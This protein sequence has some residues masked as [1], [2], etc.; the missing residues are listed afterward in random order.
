MAENIP[1]RVQFKRMTAEEWAR[2]DVILLEGEIG[3]ETDTG[4]AK[5]GNGK[6]Q[7]KDLKY[8][9]GPQGKTGET[10]PQGPPGKQGQT[11]EIGP[12][13]PPGPRGETGP[14]GPKGADGK[15]TFEQLTP[16][17]R[18]QL[19]GDKGPKGDVGPKGNDGAPGKS[20]TIRSITEETGGSYL[21]SWFGSTAKSTKVT[22][23]DGQSI[24]L[25]H[26]KDGETG[27]KGERGLPGKDGAP[28]MDGPR[29]PRGATG[30]AGPPGKD[31]ELPRDVLT[32][33]R[34]V[35]SLAG[36]VKLADAQLLFNNIGKLKDTKTGQFLDV[37][38]VDKGQTP[39]DTT[40]MIVFE[41]A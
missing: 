31:A 28:G 37:M 26:G 38:V 36:Y 20:I 39:R 29:G 4:F 12:Q 15:M 5:F 23:S 1:L 14:E 34:L 6:N 25:P 27:L 24:S 16:E 8:L 40:G 17:Q 33:D 30:P 19:K 21:G 18:E 11:G 32:I 3:F 9:S 35:N 13:G 41:R 7:F 22:F 2:S 10:G